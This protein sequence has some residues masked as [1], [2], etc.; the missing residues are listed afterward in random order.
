MKTLRL[1]A[2]VASLLLIPAISSAGVI[3]YEISD[4]G[5]L[6]VAF[7]QL[8][9]QISANAEGDTGQGSFEFQSGPLTSFSTG[10]GF[11]SYSYGAGLLTM[12]L[13]I[14]NPSGPDVF[15]T[16]TAATLPFSIDVI[17]PEECEAEE[18]ECEEEFAQ[19]FDFFISLGPGLFDPELAKVLGIRSETLGGGMP[20]GLEDILG[21]A[22]DQRRFGFEHGGGV[23]L[24]I[25]TEEVPEPGLAILL[26]TGA[27]WMAHRRRAR[28]T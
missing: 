27:T 9:V 16:F 22:G 13:T 11:S 1:V 20:L 12:Q 26:L 10:G 15:G 4:G 7:G 14:F 8:P 24:D 6:Q 23:V 18:E 28:K 17:E 25:V 5:E 19:A 2:V 3:S 21:D